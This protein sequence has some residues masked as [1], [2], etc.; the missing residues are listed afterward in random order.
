[1]RSFEAILSSNGALFR[2]FG[3]PIANRPDPE[4]TPNNLAYV[5]QVWTASR[6]IRIFAVRR[7][8]VKGSQATPR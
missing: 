4:S 3:K 1:M 6:A 2:T 7:A 8:E 5:A